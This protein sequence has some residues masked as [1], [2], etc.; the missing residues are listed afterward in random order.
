MYRDYNAANCYLLI[1][2]ILVEILFLF[3][4]KFFL[5]IVLLLTNDEKVQNH[6]LLA[7]SKPQFIDFH[8]PVGSIIL[9]WR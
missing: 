3:L 1:S 7:A 9:Q 4:L 5:L 6:Q 2:C 8:A